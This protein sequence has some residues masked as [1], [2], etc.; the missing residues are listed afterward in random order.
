MG[1]VEE[2]FSGAGF[3]THSG[4]IPAKA[5]LRRGCGTLK[6]LYSM[7]E[8]YHKI[9]NENYFGPGDKKSFPGTAIFFH[10]LSLNE[11]YKIKAPDLP[12]C[13]VILL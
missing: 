3:F 5:G 1:S 12:G 6:K 9:V 8:I 10:D 2:T 13:A 7:K 11:K 4:R